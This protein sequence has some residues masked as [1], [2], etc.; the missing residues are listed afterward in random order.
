LTDSLVRLEPLAIRHA[1]ALADAAAIDRAAYGYTSVPDGSRQADDYVAAALAQA[2]AGEALPYAVILATTGRVVGTTRFFDFG[3]PDQGRR[4]PEPQVAELGQTW[5]AA[6]V[7][8]TGVNTACK[9]LLLGLAF[10]RWR[11][12]RITLKTD[13]RNARSRTAIE[14]L[15]ARFEGIRRLHLPATDGTVRDTAYYSI[16][17]AEWPAVRARLTEKQR[18]HATAG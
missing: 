12:L 18:R 8:R 2:Q 14:R 11:A 1:S 9:L 17:T 5:Y 6:D 4:G 10:D 7:Q 16:V 3:W 13:A 15:G